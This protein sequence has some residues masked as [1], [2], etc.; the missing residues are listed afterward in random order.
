MPFYSSPGAPDAVVVS[1]VLT[2]IWDFRFFASLFQIPLFSYRSV[3]APR[4]SEQRE[5][6]LFD[7]SHSNSAR[8]N[9]AHCAAPILTNIIKIP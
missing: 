2:F 3:A 6:S 4:Y 9:L 7:F 5:G 1:G 8:T